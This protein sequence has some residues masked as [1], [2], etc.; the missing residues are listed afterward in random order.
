MALITT[1]V[2][3]VYQW[4]QT[5]TLLRIAENQNVALA[6]SFANTIWSRHAHYLSTVG[7]LEGNVLRARAETGDLDGQMRQITNG[8]PVLKVKIFSLNGNTI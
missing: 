7:H 5:A 2:F 1:A 8:L 4:H 6:T 3:Q